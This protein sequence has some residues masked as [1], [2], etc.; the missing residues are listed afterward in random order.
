MLKECLNREVW[1]HLCRGQ[2]FAELA[3]LDNT[4]KQILDRRLGEDGFWESFLYYG[5]NTPFICH[6]DYN[7]FLLMGNGP[8]P[9]SL[10]AVHIP[11][12]LLFGAPCHERLSVFVV[13]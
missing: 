4:D 6:E 5:P 2:T 3:A 9:G 8:L 7:Y 1:K 12:V 13:N 10:G 11:R